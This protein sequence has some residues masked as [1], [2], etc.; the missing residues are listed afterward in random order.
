MEMAKKHQTLS[1]NLDQK[2]LHELEGVVCRK[3]WAQILHELRDCAPLGE[4]FQNEAAL[5]GC[6]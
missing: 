3:Y 6:H 2:G 5:N 4:R 1:Q